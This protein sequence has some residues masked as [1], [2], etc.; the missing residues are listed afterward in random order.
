MLGPSRSNGTVVAQ[1]PTD[2][3]FQMH[4]VNAYEEVAGEEEGGATTIIVDC[5]TYPNNDIL[6]AL[7][8]LQ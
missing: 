3:F 5:V 6:N 4:T 2:A 1:V 7:V 8:K